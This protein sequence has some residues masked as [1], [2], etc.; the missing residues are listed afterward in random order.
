MSEIKSSP[1]Q[2]YSS[3]LEQF[4]RLV[5][6]TREK[7]KRMSLLRLG[8]FLTTLV[9]IYLAT[10][11]SVFAVILVVVI[12]VV[13][14]LITVIQYI[15]LQ[16]LLK[17]YETL[18]TINY[19]ELEALKGNCSMFA[20]GEEFNDPGHPYTSDLDFFGEQSLFQ[21]FNRSASSIG[22]HRLAGWLR[23]PLS[24]PDMI[25]HRQG[26]GK[27]LSEI[28]DW[29]QEIL[30][31]GYRTQDS[32][33]DKDDLLAW[34][35]EPAVFGHWKFRLFIALV[36]A[37]SFSVLGLTIFSVIAPAWLLL[38]LVVPYGIYSTYFTKI[39]SAYRKLSRK[40]ELIKKYSSL[41]KLIEE[42]SFTSRRMTSLVKNL[43]GRHGKPSEATRH[44]SAILDAFDQRKNMLMGFILNFLFLW[45]FIQVIRTENWQSKHR[46]ELPT[47][48]DVLAETDALC[49]LANFHFNHPKSIFPSISDD[50][51]LLYATGLG[52]PLIPHKVR[53]DNPASVP[54]W[55]HFTIITGANMAGKS[56][57]LRTV[58]VNLV[59][60]MSGSAVLAENMSF[61]PA[62]L[63]TSIRTRDSLQK[64]ESYF[65]AE[66]KRLKL[67]IDRLQEGDR[68]II[69]LDEILKGTNSRDKQSG[70]RA[71]LEKLLGYHTSGL[72]ATHDLALGEMEKDHDGQIVNK[73]FEVVIEND[74]L[75]FDY[76]LKDGIAKQMNATYLMKKMGITD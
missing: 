30:A 23:R 65:Y 73:C 36:T 51:T 34:V 26:A 3:R 39:N 8:I 62:S 35:D 38:Y 14:F 25:R 70:S 43:S 71:L 45:D 31:V 32:L 11:W 58:G 4:T 67:I 63:I 33:S 75:V 21:H 59:L 44:L 24:D 16:R 49:S 40:S 28:P 41:L 55:K 42:E 10:R 37:A 1:S 22:K 68:L 19:H 20:N 66:L 56:T 27:E 61:Q 5:K 50:K 57:Y 69:L 54:D 64:N 52:H 53:V 2:Y 13:M 9:F 48:L 12:G 18:A 72:V 46:Q 15:H 60:A 76:K 7:L 74:L 17:Y 47:W 6:T 29:R